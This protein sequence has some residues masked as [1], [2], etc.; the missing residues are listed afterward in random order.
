[1]PPVTPND[2][3]AAVTGASAGLVAIVGGLLVSRFLA[4]DSEQKAADKRLGLAKA[5][6]ESADRHL[7]ELQ[8][9]LAVEEVHDLLDETDVLKYLAEHRQDS[10]INLYEIRRLGPEIDSPDD[11]VRTHLMRA[12]A[13]MNEAVE[14]LSNSLP[15]PHKMPREEWQRALSWDSYRKEITEASSPEFPQV[16]EYVY[17]AELAMRTESASYS[18]DYAKLMS[19]NIN[20]F[21]A[22]MTPS[23]IHETNA[24]RREDLRDS[25]EQTRRHVGDAEE[26]RE[27]AF[28]ETL[29]HVRPDRLLYVGLLVLLYQ[30]VVGVIAPV[31][32]LSTG[33]ETFTDDIR[34]L[35]WWFT[36]G[37]GFLLT[38]LG[39]LAVQTLR[40]RRILER[41]A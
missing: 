8:D 25:I 3:L 30:T 29:M 2:F 24:R 26:R 34:G 19:Y 21:H 35:F 17:D 23:W 40:D 20:V 22:D 6:L 38:Y 12:V 15:E 13:A 7:T 32:I 9:K 5:E 28:M 41:N 39:W 33:P 37:L 27:K 18:T 1:V 4:I 31:Y 10:E 36:V 16:W 11:F 14:V